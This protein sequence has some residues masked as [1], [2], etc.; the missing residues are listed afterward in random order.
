[1]WNWQ[2]KDWPQFS[3]NKEEL[4]PLEDQF[5]YNA[6]LLKGSLKH[7]Q[8]EDQLVLTIDLMSQEASKTSE[9]EGDY[10]N[11]ESIQ[12]SIRQ[13][14]GLAT[15]NR[16]TSPAERGIAEMLVDLYKAF[17]EPLTH[18]KLFDWHTLLTNGRTNLV[19]IGNY[20]T[21]QDAMQIVSGPSYAPKIHFVAPPS[22]VI[23]AEMECFINWFNQTT[24]QGL[25]CL[26]S[27][28][29]ASLAHFYFV[30]IH[31]FEDGNGGIGRAIAEK[32]LSQNSGQPTLIS[33]SHTIQK[34]KKAYY[35]A[36]ESSN[37]SN[38]ITDWIVY[39]STT[40]L[41]AQL[42]TQ[43]LIEFII[44]KSKILDRLRGQLNPR[45]EKVILRLFAE[46]PE[47]F[48]GGLSADN[49]LSITKTS[50]ATATRDLQALVEKGVL[51]RTGDRKGTRYS[52]NMAF[53]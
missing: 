3:Y 12:S 28:T 15:D 18:Q 20:R 27:L 32:A 9:I 4:A 44:K 38:H 11:R 52:L 30:C 25:S 34:N 19:D 10:L 17:D 14:F 6:G 40:I 53:A 5:L 42:Y 16:K 29:R 13:N 33:L 21:H 2:Q 41:E 22:T 50:R 26:P 7:L 23:P 36:L 45:Q 46:G 1:M 8:S 47:G 39:F 31:P 37:K 35:Q 24:P 43:T 51:Q 48:K 49:Y